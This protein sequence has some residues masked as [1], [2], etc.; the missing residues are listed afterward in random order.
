MLTLLFD[1][2]LNLIKLA[3]NVHEIPVD[4]LILV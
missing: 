3:I 1:D 2:L 4:A